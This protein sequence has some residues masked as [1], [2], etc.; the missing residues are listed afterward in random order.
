MAYSRKRK[1]EYVP[2]KGTLFVD[3]RYSGIGRIAQRSG[4]M[5][6]SILARIKAAMDETYS[7]GRSDVLERLR[8]NT[9]T[10][11]E[12]YSAYKQ[13]EMQSLKTASDL[14]VLKTLEG[15]MPASPLFDWLDSLSPTDKPRSM[16]TRRGYR[17]RFTQ[18]LKIVPAGARLSEI[19]E[20][21]EKLRD[22]FNREEK[23]RSFNETKHALQ[24]FLRQHDKKLKKRNPIYQQ[25][26]AIE[27][28]SY[29]V[30]RHPN[31]LSIV[32]AFDLMDRMSPEAA[33][34]WRTLIMTGMLW[35]EYTQDGW[36]L[37]EDRVLVH[38]VKRSGRERILPRVDSNLVP[39]TLSY[40][41][42]RK[43]L[44]R[45]SKR[46][47]IPKDAR[48]VWARL[49]EEAEILETHRQA[50]MGHGS[51]NITG[52]YSTPRMVHEVLNADAAKLSAYI[53]RQKQQTKV[54]TSLITK[55]NPKAD[56]F[57]VEA[58]TTNP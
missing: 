31:A 34:M 10:I 2:P 49:M 35:K 58:K 46:T 57:F 5:S 22:Q 19:P 4:T 45:A 1:G 50:Y 18:F 56:E 7:M 33:Q 27:P 14:K 16:T 30:E 39:A 8:D 42:F 47:V 21:L 25:V 38:G 53:N 29:T 41:H 28:L 44:R 55:V 52:Y 48:N 43:E 12:F 32:D 24:A 9:I 36:D 17:G 23:F 6:H 54:R 20:Y 51:K 40:K 26:A 37:L 13:G 15:R 3:K 11:Q